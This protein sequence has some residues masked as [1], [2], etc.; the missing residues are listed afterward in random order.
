MMEQAAPT[1]ATVVDA[2]TE[3]LT[4]TWPSNGTV[5]FKETTTAPLVAPSDN[6]SV[7]ALRANGRASNSRD[8][9]SSTSASRWST[10]ASE[11]LT[12]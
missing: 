4:I 10:S 9:P 11:S 8:V 5:M 3:E 2:L 7:R 6:T 1:P 12:K